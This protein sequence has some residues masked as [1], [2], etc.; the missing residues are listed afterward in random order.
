MLTIGPLATSA[1]GIIAA[2]LRTS[3]IGTRNSTTSPISI[4]IPAG[5]VP[6]DL[7]IT[8]IATIGGTDSIPSGWTRDFRVVSGSSSF[9]VYLLYRRVA[10][11][12]DAGTVAS[13][14]VSTSGNTSGCGVMLVIQNP[15]RITTH[16]HVSTASTGTTLS[17][18]APSSVVV[19][20]P[21]RVDVFA[22]GFLS[23]NSPVPTF[24]SYTGQ[25]SLIRNINSDFN[26]LAV[27]FRENSFAYTSGAQVSSN[28][29]VPYVAASF[30]I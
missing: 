21:S 13:F 4:T 5:T 19:K 23:F 1:T 25:G 9:T 6:G 18:G 8:I 26:R 20:R 30:N 14:T 3:A 22:Q 24:S 16:G 17:T 28:F 29:N 7:L 11:V 12:G 2:R 15:L 27:Y 10:Q